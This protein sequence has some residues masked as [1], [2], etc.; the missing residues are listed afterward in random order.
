MVTMVYI[1]QGKKPETL[2]AYAH[3]ARLSPA[4]ARDM[5]EK[6]RGKQLPGGIALPE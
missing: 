5:R 2:D 6:M 4:L 1:S 3:L